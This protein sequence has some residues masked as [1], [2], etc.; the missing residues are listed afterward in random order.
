[1]VFRRAA[2]LACSFALAVALCFAAVHRHDAGSSPVSSEE[3]GCLYCAGGIVA[4]EAPSIVLAAEQVWFCE[5]V[6]APDAPA[7]RR[8]QPL[9][10]S[11]NA[12]P[13]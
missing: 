4:S 12:P 13:A 3:A 9:A 8:R 11:G 7:L 10:H 2:A 5:S 6:A 1:M